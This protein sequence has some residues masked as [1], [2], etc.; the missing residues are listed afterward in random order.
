VT[1]PWPV[2]TPE[3]DLFADLLER[4]A[5]HGDRAAYATLFDHYA[6]RVKGYLARLGLEPARAEDL[7]PRR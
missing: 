1:I 6:P 2:T 5:V 4:I 7:A 3:S